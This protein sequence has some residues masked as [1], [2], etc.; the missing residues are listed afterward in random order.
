MPGQHESF[1]QFDKQKP[2]PPVDAG[3][4]DMGATEKLWQVISVALI[5]PYS[6]GKRKGYFMP[7]KK[8]F[9]RADNRFEYKLTIGKSIKGTP[10]RKSFYST[11]SKA[12][13]KRQAEEYKVAQE[14]SARTGTAFLE[15]NYNFSEWADKWLATYKKPFVSRNTYTGYEGVVRLYLKPYF[16]S[17]DLQDIRPADINLFAASVKDLSESHVKKI[18]MCLA[19]IF[20][21][22]IEND[23]C[24]KNPCRRAR[25]TSAGQIHEKKV[26]T[27]AQIETV[28]KRAAAEMPAVAAL[29]DTGLR[30]GELLGLMWS[31]LHLVHGEGTIQV[32]RSVAS[33]AGSLVLN[34]PKKGSYRQ[35]PL[36]DRA[37]DLFLSI[38][39][40]SLY[41]FPNAVGK[42]QD[43]DDFT[44]RVKRFMK[45]MHESDPDIPIMSPHEMRHTYGTNLRRSGV[46]IY[47]IQK[48]MGHK[49]INVT[50]GTYVHN[51]LASLRTA[52]FPAQKSDDN[53]TTKAGV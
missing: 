20:E 32:Q 44:S 38:P 6:F 35:N 40:S 26:L 7:R 50:S 42:L 12:D 22:A 30:R 17:A 49:N 9:R 8:S 37:I 15:S 53:L 2:R 21:T 46:D 4:R 36:S 5:L 16:G 24:F 1:T 51:E 43:P 25:F 41:V 34:P 23:L 45:Q 47:T 27:A 31:D 18:Q 33:E 29:L 19:D 39:R 14:V 3:R 13:A 11:I 52:L 10:I 48:V 28:R